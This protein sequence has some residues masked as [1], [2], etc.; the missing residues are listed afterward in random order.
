MREVGLVVDTQDI[1]ANVKIDRKTACGNCKGCGLGS[2]DDKS[3]TIQA[4]N[5]AGAKKGDYVEVDMEA[6]SVVKAAFI[7]YTIPLLSLIVGIFISNFLFGF[8]GVESEI[9]SL[10]VG[11]LFMA[12]ALMV[13]K[14]NEPKIK[15]SN[16]YN[17]VIVSISGENFL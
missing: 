12:L 8:L 3:I 5:Q 13:I 11:I 15:K 14:L 10:A 9:G 6:P 17:P 1:S 4:L 7:I 2:S 16:Q